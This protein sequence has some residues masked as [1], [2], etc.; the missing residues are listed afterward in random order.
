MDQ[1]EALLQWGVVVGASLAA[2]VS[3]VRTRSIPNALTIPL[4]VAGFVWSA[5][6]GGIHALGDALGG[7][8]MLGFPF[9]ILFLFG[10]GGAGDAKLMGAIGA[11]LGYKQGIVVLFCV[12]VAGVVL[13]IAKAAMKKRLKFVLANV[14][15]SVYT[16]LVY[17][18]SGRR[19]QYAENGPGGLQNLP[20]DD[21]LTV[22]YGM[23]I[24][25]GVCLAAGYV[26]LW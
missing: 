19:K 7:M 4:L 16:F 10:S 22:P 24:F 3:D 25:A 14:F 15:V 11:W 9:V 6:Q 12:A 1:G 8:L 23:A 5:C 21:E 18:F 20:R 2:V 26:L 13:A 17:V